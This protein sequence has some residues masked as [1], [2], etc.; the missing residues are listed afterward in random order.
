M[1]ASVGCGAVGADIVGSGV[2]EGCGGR[3]AAAAGVGLVAGGA[4]APR[5]LTSRGGVSRLDAPGAISHTDILPKV[6]PNVMPA[7]NS[8]AAA[9]VR[10]RS[11]SGSLCI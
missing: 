11:V 10:S 7:N 3:V 2:G 1:G 8:A 9:N 4:R 6:K 5:S